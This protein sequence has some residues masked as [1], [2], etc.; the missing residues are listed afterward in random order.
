MLNLKIIS[1]F[2]FYAFGLLGPI[3]SGSHCSEHDRIISQDLEKKENIGKLGSIGD[4][5][6]I[7]KDDF[8]A[9]FLIKAAE[10]QLERISLGRLAQQIGSTN[11]ARDFGILMESE[12]K[13]SL[14]EI[15]TL[16]QSKFISIPKT[17]TE[18]SKDLYDE[19]KKNTGNNFD[20]SYS[21]MMVE[22]HIEAINLYEKVLENSEDDEIRAWTS[23]KLVDLKSHLDLAKKFKD[24]SDQL[25]P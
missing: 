5:D 14:T 24:K 10:M 6:L 13:N 17:L 22:Q 16:G 15:T 12:N 1:S 9:K 8:Y 20:K 2:F 25:N 7:I 3:L 4:Q 19:L 11:E 21:K 23:K 18:D